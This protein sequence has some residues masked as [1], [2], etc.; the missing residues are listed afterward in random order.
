MLVD[1]YPQLIG[2]VELQAAQLSASLARRGMPVMV[3]TRRVTSNLPKEG[4]LDG[5]RVHRIPPGGRRSHLIGLL[6]VPIAVTFLLRR[7]HDYDLMHV[8]DMFALLLSAYIVSLLTG[9]P[10]IVKVPTQ[11]NVARRASDTTPVSLYSRLLHH[12]LLPPF[13]WRRILRRAKAY[14]AISDEIA[15]ELEIADLHDNIWRIGNGVDTVRFSPAD[16]AERRKLRQKLNL[17]QD[18][19]IIVSH[20]RIAQRKR[21]DVLIDAVAQMGERRANL[22][23]LL[24]GEPVDDGLQARLQKRIETHGLALTVRFAGITD[25]P[26]DYLRAAD[27]FV[28][29]SEQEG[30]PNSLLEAMACGLPVI[31]S[32]IGGVTDIVQDGTNGLLFE[33]GDVNQLRALLERFIGARDEAAALGVA[34]VA[35][36][37][38]RF[39][40]DTIADRY[41]AGYRAVHPRDTDHSMSSPET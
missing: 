21:L 35:T 27:V 29:T 16:D 19:Y 8:H 32:H 39:T 1:R 9:K 33:T 11:G 23:V 13:V 6:T 7:R 31:A 41:M 25:W 18:A 22:C 34:A 40:W 36:V 37:R 15:R 24:I 4:M 20:G 26:E 10:F 17:P 2:G 14:I 30:L 3:V 12:I 38:Q 28:L 5:V